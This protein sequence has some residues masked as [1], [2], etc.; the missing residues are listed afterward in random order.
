MLFRSNYQRAKEELDKFKYYFGKVSKELEEK[1]AELMA[2]QKENTDLKTSVK[3]LESDKDKL[4]RE[5]DKAL[6]DLENARILQAVNIDVKGIR[7]RSGGKEQE[8]TKAS[9]TEQI[10]ISFGSKTYW[11]SV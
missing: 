8:T 3:N 2:M 1:K 4:G 7:I 6:S 5:K 9:K 11:Q 10:R